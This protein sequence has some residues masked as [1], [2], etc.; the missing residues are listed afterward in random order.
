[1]N[2]SGNFGSASTIWYP[3]SGYRSPS[4]GDLCSVENENDY[5]SASSGCGLRFYSG[6]NV[7]PCVEKFFRAD[8]F[9]VRC[10]KE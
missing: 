1:M 4:S 3:A 8:G 10:V 7:E 5:W 9:P 2:F 6:G